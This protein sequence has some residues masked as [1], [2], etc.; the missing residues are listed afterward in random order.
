LK[1]EEPSELGILIC[2]FVVTSR[3]KGQVI[4]VASTTDVAPGETKGVEVSGKTIALLQRR[5]QFLRH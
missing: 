3:R 5:W 1:P 4:S 2:T